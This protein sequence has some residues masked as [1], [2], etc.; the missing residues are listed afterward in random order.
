MRTGLMTSVV[1]AAAM[2][3]GCQQ[4][5]AALPEAPKPQ[6]AHLYVGVGDHVSPMG[7]LYGAPTRAALR[8]DEGRVRQHSFET[9]GRVTDPSIDPTG[10]WMVFSSSAYSPRPDLF[11][12]GVD[13]RTLTQVTSDPA[14][15]VQPTLSPDGQYVAFASNR[16]GSW[17]IYVCTVRGT[18][19]RQITRGGG[20]NLHPSWS[21]DGRRLVYCCLSARS[22]QWELWITDVSVP[23]PRQFIGTGLFPAWSPKED[24][25]AFQRPRGVGD[26]L[27]A[28]WT[29]RLT[30]GEA[31]LP[32]LVAGAPD[33]AYVSPAF[34]ADGRSLAF[35][36]IAATYEGA[37]AQICTVDIDGGNLQV[38]TH[39]LEQKFCPTW[40]GGRVYY[41]SNRDG[42]ENI[43]SVQ[44]ETAPAPAAA[45]VPSLSPDDARSLLMPGELM[46]PNRMLGD[47]R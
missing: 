27:Y 33:A 46:A 39:G 25:I 18:G 41:C 19:L 16:T 32:T 47:L 29:V 24:L 20:Q 43:W 31:S 35:A 30:G 36:S 23:G 15:E 1:A 42:Y 6:P 9:I 21:P 7:D 44:A 4:P 2:L 8:S 34:S 37:K 12:K 14:S 28:I 11:L 3:A 26:R 22:N 13:G 38:L 17:E 5:Q 40:G 45:A 10:R